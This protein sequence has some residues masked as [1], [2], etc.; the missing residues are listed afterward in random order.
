MNKIDNDKLENILDKSKLP[1]VEPAIPTYEIFDLTSRKYH[2]PEDI[3]DEDSGEFEHP[4]FSN[5]Q[6]RIC[7]EPIEEGY[8]W[9]YLRNEGDEAKSLAVC[10]KE[11]LDRLIKNGDYHS[12]EIYEYSRCT[13][14]FKCEEIGNWFNTDIVKK[15]FEAINS[16][17]EVIP[18]TILIE[19]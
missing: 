4:E 13:A 5:W 2:S 17:V 16:G 1:G 14:Y 7:E 9:Y 11:C 15:Y 12:Y 3:L 8:F 10:S 18:P 19:L 6:C